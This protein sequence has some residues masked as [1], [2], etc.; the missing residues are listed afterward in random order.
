MN[1]TS[2]YPPGTKFW[3]TPD[4]AGGTQAKLNIALITISSC[5]LGIRLYV[6]GFMTKSLGLD[7]LVASLAFCVITTQS[8]F[9][10][11][12]KDVGA[13]AHMELIPQLLLL[14]FFEG[15]QNLNLL[16]FWGVGLDRLAVLAFLPRLHKDKIYLLLVYFVSGMVLVSTII[17]FFIRLFH[18]NPVKDGWLPPLPTLNCLPQS[19]M[20]MM[21][22][23]HGILGI[24][25]DIMLM[26]LPMWVIYKKMLWSRKTFQVIAV[27]SVGIFVVIT[28]II[29]L[30][31]IR[32]MDWGTDST[33]KMATI[34]VWTD[35]ES[36]VGFWCGCF[37]SF[38]P[39]IRTVAFKLGL[40]SAL[41]SYPTGKPTSNSKGLSSASAAI[42]SKGGYLRNGS[43]IDVDA[44]ISDTNNSQEG[45][46]SGPNN[47]EMGKYGE[48]HKETTVTIHVK[49]HDSKKSKREESWADI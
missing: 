38:Q 20:D 11:H 27:F 47:Y 18:C 49:N 45:I 41:N 2:N 29:R 10:I 22:N 23:G 21:M 28:G 5:F 14:K 24:I 19:S 46:M 31:Y 48:I 16:Y 17:C 1:S 15:L 4:W 33:F 7:D 12:L 34:G 35:L 13:G 30:Y 36:H 32:T 25:F 40:R 42:R 37:P 44:D 9:N 8:G 39:I 43:G 6:R 26:A 3:E